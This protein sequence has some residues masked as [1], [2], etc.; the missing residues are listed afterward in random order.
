MVGL[1]CCECLGKSWPPLSKESPTQWQEI[2][3]YFWPRKR[4]QGLTLSDI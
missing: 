3:R 2:K 1:M 4:I